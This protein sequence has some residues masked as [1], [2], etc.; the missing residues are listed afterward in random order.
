MGRSAIR[1]LII[2]ASLAISGSTPAVSQQLLDNGRSATGSDTTTPCGATTQMPGAGIEGK[3]GCTGNLS[4]AF[5]AGPITLTY[6]SQYRAYPNARPNYGFGVS[7]YAVS[8]IV[9]SG[10]KRIFVAED[11]TETSFRYVAKRKVWVSDEDVRGDLSIIRPL[12]VGYQ[13]EELPSPSKTIYAQNVQGIGY[14]PTQSFDDVGGT[15]TYA[16]Y[17][18]AVPRR[19][20]DNATKKTIE[21][22]TSNGL[23]TKVISSE[24]LAGGSDRVSYELIPNPR[25]ELI[26]IKGPEGATLLSYAPGAPGQLSGVMDPQGQA[27]EYELSTLGRL[28]KVSTRTNTHIVSYTKNSVTTKRYGGSTTPSSPTPQSPAQHF[29]KTVYDDY[30]YVKE[31]RSGDGDAPP[32]RRNVTIDRDS[33]G[34]LAKV[35]SADGSVTEWFYNSTKGKSCEPPSSAVGYSLFATCIKSDGF[36]T[37][38]TRNGSGLPTLESVKGPNGKGPTTSYTWSGTDLTNRS[39]KDSS[40]R[41]TEVVSIAYVNKFPIS[42]TQESHAFVDGFDALSRPAVLTC[43]SGLQMALKA[44]QDGS[45]GSF[46]VEGMEST[47][48]TSF[49]GTGDYTSTYTSQGVAALLRGN[50][51]GSSVNASAGTVPNQADTTILSGNFNR[52]VAEQRETSS[53]TLTLSDSGGSETS[54]STSTIVTTPDRNQTE[55]T[56][57]SRQGRL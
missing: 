56:T 18:G 44:N 6:N 50:F 32:G 23:A 38:I 11:G 36:T 49:T 27:I 47:F 48:S 5:V 45:S 46:S 8:H 34:R 1:T 7:M 13:L 16:D 33:I 4:L 22:K 19:V 24:S 17:D 41:T 30:G 57:T 20:T 31:V 42:V 37:T 15:T 39:V 35:R 26:A 51:L 21:I 12:P 3:E 10:D 52:S 14:F 40:N 55:S 2:M 25:K 9:E 43:A 54:S 28:K 29:T 53:Q